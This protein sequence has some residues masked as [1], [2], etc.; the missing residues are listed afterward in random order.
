MGEITPKCA[1]CAW[2]TEPLAPECKRCVGQNNYTLRKHNFGVE[3][4]MTMMHVEPIDPYF[5]SSLKKRLNELCRP[6]VYDVDYMPMT[7]TIDWDSKP[8]EP[9][10]DYTKFYPKSEWVKARL[11]AL[12]GK[13]NDMRLPEIEKVIFNDPATIVIW[14][15]GAKTVVKAENEPFDPEKGLAMAIAKKALGNQGNYYEVF[16]K[17]IP[18]EMRNTPEM[19]LIEVELTPEMMTLIDEI[20]GMVDGECGCDNCGDP[21]VPESEILPYGCN[22]SNCEI[23][24][25]DVKTRTKDVCAC[26]CPAHTG[27]KRNAGPKCKAGCPKYDAAFNN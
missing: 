23:M 1:G 21:N 22:K 9:T 12:F 7:Y 20:L 3:K 24:K 13:E 18:E 15:G 10:I 4:E 25:S 16:K 17:W 11:N 27:S 6:S 2:L 19:V 5:K 14:K 8:Y 26:C